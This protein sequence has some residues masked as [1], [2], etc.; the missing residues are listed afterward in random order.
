ME[1]EELERRLKAIDEEESNK[2][3]KVQESYRNSKDVIKKL[4]DEQ[5]VCGT[6]VPILSVNEEDED[7]DKRMY[8]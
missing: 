7:I 5:A 1:Y 8:F 3:E 6:S 2:I 4:L